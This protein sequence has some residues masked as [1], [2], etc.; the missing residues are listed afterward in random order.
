MVHGL[1]FNGLESLIL[2]D[3]L[4]AAGF[5]PEPFRYH[6]MHVSLRDA[7]DALATRLRALDGPAH[8]VAHSLGGLVTCEALADH[9]DL[10]DGRVV[11]LGSPVR[12][13]RAARE[14][15]SRWYGHAML[16]SLAVAELARERDCAWRSA[17]QVGVIAGSRSAGLGRMFADLPVPNDG[18]VCV[19]ETELPGASARLVLDV[20]HTGML[21]SSAVA[22]A[23]VQ[24]LVTGKFA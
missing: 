5:A 21:L 18:T 7:A 1:W 22:A 10:P 11:L 24:F 3:R 15:A 2:R 9:G 16:G 12:G 19:D 20:S 23:T 13:A 8:V 17:R 4:R 6:S 14:V